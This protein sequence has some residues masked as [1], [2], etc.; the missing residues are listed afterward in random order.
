MSHDLALST[1]RANTP[2]RRHCAS[3]FTLKAPCGPEARLF[4]NPRSDRRT[5]A[6]SVEDDAGDSGPPGEEE[7]PQSAE[8]SRRPE[9]TAEPPHDGTHAVEAQPEAHGPEPAAANDAS[10]SIR[11]T[12]VAA[13]PAL[14]APLS[15]KSRRRSPCL[16]ACFLPSFRPCLLASFLS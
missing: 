13:V 11:G 6:P 12:S 9:I 4:L 3:D 10:C 14:L 8:H 5:D 16:L 1:P 2:K 15:A 7:T